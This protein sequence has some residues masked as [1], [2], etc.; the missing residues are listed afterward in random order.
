M[1]SEVSVYSDESIDRIS[2]NVY[3]HFAEHL[4]RCVYGGIW[5]GDDDRVETSDGIRTD[6]V[7]LLRDLGIPVLRWPGGCFADDYHWEDGVGPREERPTRRNLWWAQGR[8]QEFFDPNDFGTDEFLRLCD[9]L[10]A[11]PYIAVNVGTGTP[12]EALDW[13]EYCNAPGDE[14]DVAARRVENGHEEPYDVTYWGIG[15][16]NWGCGGRFVPDEYADEY[17]RFANYL[18]GFD[19]HHNPGSAEFIACGHI[20]EEWNDAFFDRLDDGMKFGPGTFLGMGSPYTLLDHF[21]VH[22]YYQAGDDVEFSDDQHYR[23]FARARKV[24][25]DIDS[26]AE[27][28][29]RYVPAEDVGIILDEWGVWHPQATPANGLE[30]D[31]T[32]RDALTAAGVFDIVHDRA[33]VVSMANIAQTVNVLQCLVQ[34]DEDDAWATPTYHVFDLYREHAGNTAVETTVRAEKKFFEGEEHDVPL[35]SA[36]ASVDDDGD[37]YVTASNRRI[38]AAETVEIDLDGTVSDAS[39]T[40]L[41]RDQGPR[42]YSTKENATAFAPEELAVDADGDGC[43]VEVPPSSVVG[44]SVGR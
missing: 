35:V 42:E 28:I 15:N 20:T 7:E 25:D 39:G 9:M 27:T 2:E 18:G 3:G 17:R 13:I 16:E 4:G 5:V 21:S 10:D 1:A 29:S 41:F 30:Q 43:T 32:V 24:A 22:R 37:V 40:V 34:T 14:S 23:I 6:T 31:N 36:S 8:K 33:D 12:D 26:A 11:E 44:V 19:D 38:D